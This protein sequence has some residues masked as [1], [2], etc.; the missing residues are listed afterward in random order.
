MKVSNW[1]YYINL[2]VHRVGTSSELNATANP[3]RFD[4]IQF[5]VKA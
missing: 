3:K 5:F 1:M 4:M 2:F